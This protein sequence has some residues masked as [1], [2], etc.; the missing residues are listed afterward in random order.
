M[1]AP[2][3]DPVDDAGHR[4]TRRRVSQDRGMQAEFRRATVDDVSP[5]VGLLADDAFGAARERIGNGVVDD[6]YL[7][8]FAAIDADPRQLL[9]VGT[10]DAQVVATLQ[11]SFIPY[12]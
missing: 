10:T 2:T 1:T 9:V 12:L 3:R 7:Q 5:I 6:A 8:T 11:M 4:V